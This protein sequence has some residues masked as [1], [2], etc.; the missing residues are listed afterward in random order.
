MPPPLNSRAGR[1]VIFGLAAVGVVV[2][3]FWPRAAVKKATAPRPPETAAHDLVER[4]N[5]WFLGSQTN[6]PFSGVMVERFPGGTMRARV[7]ISNGW[8]DGWSETWHTNGMAESRE[9]FKHGVSDGT[10][11]RWYEDGHKESEADI[12][13][14]KVNGVFERWHE[15]GQLAEKI[16]MKDGQP[17][18]VAWAWYPSGFVKAETTLAGGLASNRK[19]WK[20]GEFK[21]AQ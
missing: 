12:V 19:T 5:R 4:G 17:T 14:G 10:R 3:L 18:G 8:A 7:E 2:V 16:Q 20:D 1:L 13:D 6:S 21:T 15:N 11:D 9:H